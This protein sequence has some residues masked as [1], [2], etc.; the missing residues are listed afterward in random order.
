MSYA[1]HTLNNCHEYEPGDEIIG[2]AKSFT[3]RSKNECLI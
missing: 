3:E 2:L 1:V